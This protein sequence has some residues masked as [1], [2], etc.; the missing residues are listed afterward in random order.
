MA[1]AAEE[2]DVVESDGRLLFMFQYVSKSMKLKVDR[3]HKMMA[4]E[5]YRC[6]VLEFLSQPDCG[7]LMLSLSSSGALVPSLLLPFNTGKNKAVYFLKRE[8]VAITVDN[9]AAMLVYGDLSPNALDQMAILLDQIFVPML[10][11]PANQTTWPKS[12][13]EDVK[14]MAL[15]LNEIVYRVK[16]QVSGRT[17]LPLP[18]GIEKVADECEKLCKSRNRQCDMELKYSIESCV[19]KWANQLN[20]VLKETSASVFEKEPYPKPDADLLFWSSRTK[21]LKAIYEQLR[22]DKVMKMAMILELTDSAYFPCF[23]KLFK[24]VVEALEE[25]SEIDRHL[26]PLKKYVNEIEDTVFVDA[27]PLFVPLI[28]TIALIWTHCPYFATSSKLINLLKEVCNLL[29]YESNKFLDPSSLFRG[30]FEET[31]PRL[32][33]V[34]ANLQSF[35]SLFNT[36]CKNLPK[37]V[38]DTDCKPWSFDPKI[39]FKTYD[40]YTDRIKLIEDLFKTSLEY[41]R[42]EKVEVGGYHGHDLSS[43]LDVILEDF[44]N[45]LNGFRCLSLDLMDI[46]DN[47]LIKEYEKFQEK[48]LDFDKRLAAITVTAFDDCTNLE[49]LFKMINVFGSLLERSIIKEEIDSKYINMIHMFSDEINVVS[50]I[51]NCTYQK[52][53]ETG[54]PEVATTHWPTV[55]RS[56]LFIRTMSARL[57]TPLQQ[58]ND[59]DHECTKSEDAE[60]MKSKALKIISFLVEF[61]RELVNKWVK[62]VPADIEI[63]LAKSLLSRNQSNLLVVNFD[64]KLIAALREVRYMKMLEVEG[65]PKEAMDLFERNEELHLWNATLKKTA[66]WYNKMRQRS[67]PQEFDIVSDEVEIIDLHIKEIIENNDWNSSDNWTY[68]IQLHDKVI[69]LAERMCRSQENLNKTMELIN[70]WN[71]EPLYTR[72]KGKKEALLVYNDMDAINARYNDII[73]VGQ[74][75]YYYIMMNFCLLHNIQIKDT[76]N[77]DEE[78]PSEA[79]AD[80]M[81]SSA[82]PERDSSF[83]IAES[84]LSKDEDEDGS[85]IAK[86]SEEESSGTQA[87]ALTSQLFISGQS[88]SEL[89]ESGNDDY[90]PIVFGAVDSEKKEFA[91][92]A[93]RAKY[94][95]DLWETKIRSNDEDMHPVPVHPFQK[96]VVAKQ[97][98]SLKQKSK[99]KK[100]KGNGK[101]GPIAFNDNDAAGAQMKRIAFKNKSSENKN[102][103]SINSHSK[104]YL[105]LEM[106]KLQPESWKKLIDEF[107]NNPKVVQRWNNYL[108]LVDE[109]IEDGLLHAVAAS[110]GFFIEEMNPRRLHA[111]LFEAKMLLTELDIHFEPSLEEDKHDTQSL[112]GIMSL[113]LSDINA[114][115]LLIPRIINKPPYMNDITANEDISGMAS[116]TMNRISLASLKV[117]KFVKPYYEYSYLWLEDQPEHLREF[118]KYAKILTPEEL[119]LEDKTNEYGELYLKEMEPTLEQFKD[120]IDSYEEL[121]RKIS[122]MEVKHSI[123]TWLTIDLAHF[124]Q[125]LL[126]L[127]AKWALLYKQYLIDDIDFRLKELNNF[128]EEAETGLQVQLN[129]GDY[130]GLVSVMGYLL[131]VKERQYETDLMFQPIRETMDLIKSYGLDFEEETYTLLSDVPDKWSMLKRLAIHVKSSASPLMQEESNTIRKRLAFFDIKQGLYKEEFKKKFFFKWSCT[132]PYEE[133]DDCH[134]EVVTLELECSMLT[135]QAG[136]FE[137]GVSEFKLLKQIRKELKLAKI[138]WDYILVVRSWLHEWERTE[139]KKIDSESMDMELKKFSKELRTLDKDMRHWEIYLQLEGIVKNMITA[140]RAITELQ[141]PAIRDRHW[142]QLMSATKVKFVIDAATTL[143]DLLDLNLYKYEDEVKTIVDKSVK[144]QAMEKTL[145]DLEQVWSAM[146]FEYDPHP[147]SG[148]SVLRVNEEVIETLEENQAQLQNMLNS[149]FIAHFLDEV[150][151]WQKKLSNADQVIHTWLEVQRTWMYLESIFIGSDD[152][153]KQL[154]VDSETFDNVDNTFKDMLREIAEIPKVVQATNRNGL[155]E[156]LERLQTDLMKCEKALAQYLETKRL[157]YPRFYFVSAADLLD[158]LSNGN[159]PILVGRHLTKLYDSVRKLKFVEEDGVQKAIGMWSKDG[160][161]VILYG[162]CDCSGQVEKWLANVTESMRRTGR[163]YFSLAVKNYD[164][165]PREQWVFD[166][167]AQAAL[168]ATQIWWAAEVNM[169]FGRLEE[170]Y[171]NALKDYQKKQIIQLNQLISLLLGELSDDDRQKITTICTVDVHSRDVVAKLI[172]LRVDNARAFQWQSQLRH[173]WDHKL[174][175]C[176]VN[177]CDAQFR[178]NYEYLGNVPRLV[179]TPLTDRCYITLTQSLHLVMGGAPAGPAG[180]GKTETTK[181]LGKGI[182]VM[183]YVFNCSEQMDYKS[184]G[185]IYKGLSQT[186]AW[187]CF[188]E[189]NRISVEVLSVVAVQ[190]KTVLDAIKNKKSKFNFQGEIISLVPTVGMFITMNPGYAGRAELPEN[191]KTLFRPCAMVV[192][193]YELICE[194][195]LIG[196][197]FQEARL[198]GKKFLTLYSLCKELL[199][200]QDHYDWGL[201]AIKSVLVVAGKLKRG[202]RMR[203]E[204]Q[205]L[206]RALR[207]FNMPKIVTDDLPIFLGLIGDLFPALDVPRK[208]DLDFEKHVR[209]GAVDLKLQPEEGFVLKVV[210]LQEL[211]AVRHSVFI[212][213]SAGTGKSMVWK[214]LHKTYINM[215]KKP[216]YNDIEPKAVTNNELFGIINPQTREWKDGLFSVLIREQANMVGDGPKWMVMDGD[217]DPMWIESLNTVMDDNKVLTLASNERI[218]LTPSMRLLF[219]ISNLRTATPAT[220]SRAGILYINPSDLGWNPYVASWLDTRKNESE[221]TIVTALFD[222]YVPAT[223]EASRTKFKKITPIAEIAHV[224]MLCT[225]LEALLIPANIPAESPKDWY[226][227]YFVFAC[228]W[229]FGSASFQD[230]LIDWRSEFTK[231][232]VNEFKTVRIP[233]AVSSGDHVF[234]YFIDQETKKF[235]PWTDKLSKFEL[236]YELPLQ[237]TLVNTAETTRV[238]YFLDLLIDKQKPLMLV[239]PAG[240]GKSVLIGD[241][242]FSLSA[243]YTVT[244][245]SFNFYTTSEMLQKVIEKPLEKK[246]GR[247]YGPPGN[248]TMIYFIDDMNMPEVDRYGTVQP[249]TLIRQ[250]MDYQHWYDRQKLTLKDIHNI[251]FLST[252]NPTAGSFTI[253]PR[254]QRH[255]F[256]FALSFPGL[257]ALTHIYSSVLLQHIGNPQNKFSTPVLK[258][259]DLIIQLAQQTHLRVQQTFLPTAIKFHYIFNLRDLSN[260][261]QAIIMTAPECIPSPGAFVRIWMHEAARVYGDKLVDLK[262]QDVFNKMLTET[263]KKVFTLNL[264]E[265]IHESDYQCSPLIY[266]HFVE[267]IGDPKYLRMPSWKQLNNLLTDAMTQYNDLI[268]TMNLVLFEDAMAHVCRINRVM[269]MPRGNA[270]LVG[271]GGSGKQSLSRLSAFISGLEPFQIQLK[272]GYSTND[273]K[274]DLTGLYMKAGLKNIGIMFLMTDSQVSDERFLVLINDLLS[275]GEIPDLFAEDEVDSIIS[276][277]GPEAKG[278][279]LADTRQNCWKFFIDRVRRNLKTILCF[280]PVGST[281]RVRARKFP[282]LVNCTTIDWFLEWPQEALESVSHRFL[283][284]MDVLPEKLTKSMSLIMAFIHMSVN[285]MSSIYLLNERRYNYTTPKSFLELISLYSKLLGSKH[286]EVITKIDRLQN[287]LQKLVSCSQ[288]VGVLKIQLAEQGL[289]VAQ[290]NTAASELIQIVSK[291]TDIVSKEKAIAKEEERKCQIIEEDVKI[292]QKLCE[293]DLAMALPALEAAQN[294]L[295]TLNKTNLTEMKSF[296]T[297]PEAVA[298]VASAVM[299]LLSKKGKI[300]KDRSWKA[301]KAMMGSADSFLNA[302][303]N[304]DKENILPEIVKAVQPYIEDPQF[305]PETVITKSSAAA[306]LCAW[307]INIMKFHEVWMIV[308]PKKKAEAAA[309]AELLQAQTRLAEIE[310]RISKLEEQLS[311][312]TS[313]FEEALAEKQACEAEEEKTLQAI[314]LANRLVNGLASEN[315]RWKYTVANLSGQITTLPGDILLVTAFISYVGSFTRH[316]REELM[317]NHWKPQL[318]KYKP[319]IPCTPDIEPMSMLTDDAQIASWNNEGLPNDRM[320]AENATVLTN[321]ERWP[322]MID[323]QLQGVKW[324]KSKYG[325]ELRVIRLGHKHYLDKI[326]KAVTDGATLLIENIGETIDPVLDNLLGRNLIR[327]GK[328]L[329]IGDRE[330]DYSSKFRLILQTKLANPH[331]Q[332]EIQ[333]QTTLINFTVTKDG[334]EEQLLAEVVKAERPD[335]EALKANLTKQQNNFKIQLKELEDELLAR[336]S[337]AGPDILSDKQLVEK[338]ESTK[339]TAETIE[340]KVAEAKV[341]SS[342]IDAAREMYRAVA[343]RASILYFIVNDLNKINPLYQFSL[344]AFS[345]VF[346]NAIEIAEP[347]EEVAVRVTNLVENISYCTFRYTSRGLFECDKL[348]FT[349]QMTIQILLRDRQISET[350]LDYL[351]RFPYLPSLVSPVDFLTN[352]LWGGVKALS[353]IDEFR[354]LDKDIEG[355]AK[356]WKK[357]VDGECPEKDKFPQDWKNKTPFQRL[358]MMRTLRPDRMTYAIKF[359]IEEK[360][361]S[362]FIDARSIEFEKSFKETSSTVPVFFILS[363]GVDPT[364]DV[365]RVGKKLGFTAERKN[366]H[367]VSLGQ[368]QE[369]VAEAAIEKGARYGHWVILQTDRFGCYYC[370]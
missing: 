367:N 183:V 332:P 250:F 246:A 157:A 342:K 41:I 136:L 112:F 83:D 135:E 6:I 356:R 121:Y 305:T 201:R 345:I 34:L 118:L 87:S 347:S 33:K 288:Q 25:A 26:C 243:N 9:V 65:I 80:A 194:I 212:I 327:K 291:E 187:G 16:G 2:E 234:N 72:P 348:I 48:V 11:S 260:I 60:K 366:L 59:F 31:L 294:A 339:K 113:I 203:P 254:L 289:I 268:G 315:S 221:K 359:F 130:D 152:I 3:W 363:P 245:I 181:D 149:K 159:Q 92:P 251:M 299:V 322:L 43:R 120:M 67:R 154:P 331:Y 219:E 204:D 13:A 319:E 217:I 235:R 42:L 62:Q 145:I 214:T 79:A 298:K 195:M 353:M 171:D 167:P 309:Q 220:V 343:I 229:A 259:A 180:T 102:E 51:V 129:R 225:L 269:E 1:E 209:Q 199:S 27:E 30:E 139:W 350:E 264:I 71:L 311:V 39:V 297:P 211:F 314:D 49:Q 106:T 18:I 270:L 24:S 239:G 97:G 137:V 155:Q 344:K 208:R 58:I 287:G 227:V 105:I 262:D 223:L 66:E 46:N 84:L 285:K 280:S 47:T 218:A 284:E 318:T 271:V 273:L 351:L 32:S 93:I 184:C 37:L 85:D 349:A 313:Q 148:C 198:L 4:T 316:Y 307:V 248:K 231:W 216:Y 281:L 109:L 296:G 69:A 78:I 247:N 320:S 140:L 352:T 99:K 253:D 52:Y 5:E 330:I 17:L 283:C 14:K 74:E 165:K 200:K 7:R 166:Y 175:D 304:Y 134:A 361:G 104:L 197:G 90:S 138:M 355:S 326:E 174:E 40:K 369:G 310:E 360:L 98:D 207:D 163:Y 146:Q 236:D 132:S 82:I 29:I 141:N 300:P 334:L 75:I 274:A 61:E 22:E 172:S 131:K 368:G 279:G 114:M 103:K 156:K 115:A 91:R 306:G 101:V 124:K 191:L 226:E 188:D 265:D 301:A 68:I 168:V 190:V 173:R 263:I 142:K 312:L 258:T 55:S 96:N 370:K 303:V 357:F 21:N 267:G 12:V 150:S 158:I 222:K 100:K 95:A 77:I 162:V 44:N 86:L 28:H 346:Q 127:C 240:S 338:L 63:N 89:S 186:G 111:P 228:I 182:G 169:A 213:G 20:E 290:K 164:D 15:E 324:I 323:P 56:I 153:R 54:D 193:D 196:E 53:E 76:T 64:R 143:K 261:F 233:V 358:C 328:V 35:R 293:E 119:E 272:K 256:V 94:L 354:N 302:L 23:E 335:L 249:H 108:N 206:M 232:W 202:D 337:A 230:Q 161:Y 185:N 110:I 57:S 308:L 241:K 116:D 70:K 122:E 364:R 189:F 50:D 178:Y 170:G 295:N 160:E 36:Y 292:K 325:S 8:N 38:K 362:K 45:L 340:V 224:Q 336:L 341:T 192:P 276:S 365:E 329:K 333:A 321:S 179:I 286:S 242:L 117:K 275:S 126:N 123:D 128:I 19:I 266:C 151:L 255:F 278:S 317:N 10:I 133:I 177:I 215:K 73:A 252:M 81:K 210:Q 125:A 144:E 238:R 257:E 282:A 176:F 237:S 147:R 107:N 205:V 244:N 277:I 88:E